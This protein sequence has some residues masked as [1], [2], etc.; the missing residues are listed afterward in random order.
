PDALEQIRSDPEE[1][2]AY[3][4]QFHRAGLL[5]VG[6]ETKNIF[7]KIADFIRTITGTVSKWDQ[8][9]RLIDAIYDG[10]FSDP[11]VAH[12][13][14]DD[15]KN[16]LI[17]ERVKRLTGPV[18]EAVSKLWTPTTERMLNTQIPALATL[19]GL[20]HRTPDNEDGNKLGFLQERQR[21]NGMFMNEVYKGLNG[22]GKEE[23]RQ[24]VRELRDGNPTTE[25][26]KVLDGL[27]KKMWTYMDD[28]GVKRA[29]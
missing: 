28:A 25:R 7:N 8:A 9:G 2:L 23:G 17:S 29:I 10:K 15:M 12:L 21:R 18:G 19:A 24:L 13:V 22:V 6:P 27:F 26:G 16:E 14:I 20:Y 1:R 5:R 3:M 11:S 4:F